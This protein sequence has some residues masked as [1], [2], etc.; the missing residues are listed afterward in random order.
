MWH[1][2]RTFYTIR[3]YLIIR[4]DVTLK[5]LKFKNFK[6]DG[7]HLCISLNKWNFDLL[8]E[9]TRETTQELRCTVWVIGKKLDWKRHIKLAE[10]KNP[11][12][13]VT[14][15][16]HTPDRHL[17]ICV[18]RI[19]TISSKFDIVT[20]DRAVST[21][22]QR[23]PVV[24]RRTHWNETFGFQEG[25]RISN[26]KCNQKGT[27]HCESVNV[28]ILLKKAFTCYQAPPKGV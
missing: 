24:S 27:G 17:L 15:D 14:W 3:T 2:R 23:L 8:S 28:Q 20:T 4:R 10:Q 1:H 18:K 9:Y 19:F 26:L 16:T 25:Q 22:T 21:E 7:T 6:T 12:C 5:L 13:K 11:N